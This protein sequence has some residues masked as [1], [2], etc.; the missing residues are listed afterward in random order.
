MEKCAAIRARI[1]IDDHIGG[2]GDF[3]G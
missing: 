1:L 2:A 3:A